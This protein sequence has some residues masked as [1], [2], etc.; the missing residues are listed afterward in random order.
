VLIDADVT[1][2][3]SW[4]ATAVAPLADPGIG[5]V[6]GNQW[7]EPGPDATLGTWLRS[8]WNAGALVPTAMNQNPWAGTCAMRMV[9]VHRAGLPELWRHSAVDDGPIQ[10]ALGKLGLRVRFV[11]SLIMMNREN[12]TADYVS[13]YITRMLTWSRLY[14]PTFKNTLVHSLTTGG[15]LL[16]IASVGI[17]STMAGQWLIFTAVLAGAA[18]SNLL[19]VLAYG[20]VRRAVRELADKRSETMSKLGALAMWKVFLL[21][22]IA[23]FLY[24]VS[25]LRALVIR[26]V[27]WRQITYEIQNGGRVKMLAYQPMMQEGKAEKSKWSI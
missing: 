8:L 7:F 16:L 26:R 25:C 19:L 14:E 2:F 13:R 5:C 22:P 24:V 27:E 18:I 6:T 21:L 9:D 20:L 23:Q 12:C 3:P 17:W 10:G 1:P 15:L 11:P 4:L